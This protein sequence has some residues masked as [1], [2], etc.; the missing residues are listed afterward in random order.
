MTDEDQPDTEAIEGKALENELAA[1]LN[2]YSAENRSDTP[3][4]ILAAFMLDC[5]AA[6]NVAF[7]QRETWYGRGLEAKPK[8]A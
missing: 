6:W 1:L 8:V 4:F 2:R 5:L 7:R 3:D